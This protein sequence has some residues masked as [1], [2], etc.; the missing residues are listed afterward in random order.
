MIKIIIYADD[1]PII[2]MGINQEKLETA[3]SINMREG[4]L[5]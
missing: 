1:P 4:R 3:V 5:L 2:N